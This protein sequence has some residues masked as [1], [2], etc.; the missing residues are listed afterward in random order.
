MIEHRYLDLFVEY[1]MKRSQ[2][3]MLADLSMLYLFSHLFILAFILFFLYVPLSPDSLAFLSV[4][5]YSCDAVFFGNLI[6]FD[7]S[8]SSA[9]RLAIIIVILILYAYTRL[10]TYMRIFSYGYDI[11]K[12]LYFY[13]YESFL[14]IFKF[15]RIKLIRK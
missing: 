4:L 15:V 3:D 10:L 9:F 13:T 7:Y 8:S 11:S 2:R 14:R 6:T 12:S 5:L 1:V